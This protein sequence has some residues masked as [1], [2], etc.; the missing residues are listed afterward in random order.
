M[1]TEWPV[2]P[3]WHFWRDSA[4]NLEKQ[5]AT[6]AGEFAP[7]PPEDYAGRI[8]DTR[9]APLILRHLDAFVRPASVIRTRGRSIRAVVSTTQIYTHVLNRG[10]SGVRSPLDAG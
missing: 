7:V 10:G 2:S 4:R 8:S 3:D 6:T 1:S 5:Y 9:V